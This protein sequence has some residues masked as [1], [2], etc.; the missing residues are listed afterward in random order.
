MSILARLSRPVAVIGGT[1]S[2]AAALANRGIIKVRH[3]VN[4]GVSRV[5]GV[6]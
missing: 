3:R 4:L 2:K 5:T 1:A 6:N